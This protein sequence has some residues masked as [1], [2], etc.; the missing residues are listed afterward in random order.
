MR[1]LRLLLKRVRYMSFDRMKDMILRV[2]KESNKS[3]LYIMF[4]MVYC[5]L[6]Y[7]VGYLDYYVFGFVF[8]NAAERKTYMTMPLNNKLFKD[9]NDTMMADNF[10]DKL[11]FN[12]IFNDY[13]GRQWLDLRISSYEDFENFTIA[14]NI[15]IVKPVDAFSGKGI[16]KIVI[17]GGSD[18]AQIYK[19]LIANEQFVV[20]ECLEQHE[21]MNALNPSSINTLRITSLIKNDVVHVMYVLIRTSDGTKFID[22][23]GSGGFYAP[24]DD[25]GTIFKPGFTEQ[26]GVH[27]VHPLTKTMFVGFQVPL[28]NEAVTLVKTCA[29]LT[30]EVRYCGWDV[31][32]T[33]K[34]PVLI[35]GNPMPGYDIPQNH[36]HLPTRIGLLPK[37]S[38]VLKEEI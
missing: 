7:N 37:F 34:G 12:A 9:L 10:N 5:A 26:D 19:S 28:Y 16:E 35:E 24:V 13:L 30:P 4:D 27:D 32:I 1:R 29:T 25:S 17:D 38:D 18:I 14:N 6:R 15:L 11:K 36:F 2:K 22:N 33:P 3:Y 8:C 21:K 20:E 31:A 23:I